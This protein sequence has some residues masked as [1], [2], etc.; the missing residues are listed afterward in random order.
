MDTIN[1]NLSSG[2]TIYLSFKNMY[3][4]CVQKDILHRMSSNW[5]GIVDKV[6]TILTCVLPALGLVFSI[7]ELTFQSNNEDTFWVSIIALVFFFFDTVSSTI[8]LMISFNE[9]SKEHNDISIQYLNIHRDI[10]R[11]FTPLNKDELHID[12]ALVRK[13]IQDRIS[14]I[15][16]NNLT[17][18]LLVSKKFYTTKDKSSEYIRLI[19]TYNSISDENNIL[20]EPIFNQII[21]DVNKVN[22]NIIFNDDITESSIDI[23]DLQK[24]FDLIND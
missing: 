7:L 12:L 18:P 13:E 2:N 21:N 11:I 10:I 15:S 16:N 3:I 1:T 4:E 6:I 22:T 23:P 20:F 24:K 8:N 5:Y 19:E 9:T 17:I 14:N